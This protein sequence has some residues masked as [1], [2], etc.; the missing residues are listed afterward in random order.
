VRET[1]ARSVESEIS[2]ISGM[3]QAVVRRVE[4][5]DGGAQ[6]TPA[7]A[8]LTTRGRELSAVDYHGRPVSGEGDYVTPLCLSHV[9]PSAT[10]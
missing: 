5:Q 3:A 4:A 10:E 2:A 6:P 8:L 9:D 1:D 7:S